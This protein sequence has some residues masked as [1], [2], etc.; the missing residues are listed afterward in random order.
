MKNIIDTTAQRILEM[1]FDKIIV[2]ADLDAL[3]FSYANNIPFLFTR[4]RPPPLYSFDNINANINRDEYFNLFVVSAIQDLCPVSDYVR[5]IRIEEE[6]LLKVSTVGNT[7]IS[8]SFKELYL[9][10]DHCLTGLD[11]AACQSNGSDNL[12]VDHFNIRGGHNH[13]F[14]FLET[15][16]D[17]VKKI[18]F[19]KSKRFIRANRHKKD[20]VSLSI[21]K[22]KNLDNFDYSEVASR[23]KTMKV[24]R[25]NGI[26]GRWDKTAQKNKPVDIALMSREIFPLWKNIYEDLPKNFHMLNEV[27]AVTLNM[28][29]LYANQ[30]NLHI[31]AK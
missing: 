18:V 17:F 19:V 6:N 31:C 1:S 10:D 24:M 15:N 4:R 11:S 21:V 29:D 28:E 22:T 20:C 30:R 12:V 7:V 2:G 9:S 13:Q 5:N 3:R 23:L 16:S 25:N 14:E 27:P 26:T 8:L